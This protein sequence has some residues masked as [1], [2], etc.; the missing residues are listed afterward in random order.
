MSSQPAEPGERSEASDRSS[1]RRPYEPWRKLALAG[2]LVLF[3][4]SV[5]N[6][7]IE[8]FPRAINML[9]LGIGWGFLAAGFGRAMM[10]R[11]ARERATAEKKPR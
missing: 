2:A 1:G 7:A 8:D 3:V 9:S 10:D 4:G 6:A 11:R 5:L